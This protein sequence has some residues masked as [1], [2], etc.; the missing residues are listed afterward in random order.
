M[1]TAQKRNLGAA[2]V[3]LH[4]SF[5]QKSFSPVAWKFD[6]VVPSFAS[7]GAAPYPQTKQI[8][9]HDD[10]DDIP[11]AISAAEITRIQSEFL[12]ESLAHDLITRAHKRKT[13][14]EEEALLL[15][16]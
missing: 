16:I 5:S 2:S 4:K 3:F 8:K 7:L 13:R 9:R 15:M 12:S 14:A 10:T 11:E 6:G 1:A